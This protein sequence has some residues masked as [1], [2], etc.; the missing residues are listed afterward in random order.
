MGKEQDWKN[1]GEQILDS[2]SGALN[3]GD[4]REL[5]TLV[6]DTVNNAVQE[7]KKQAE[8]EKAEYRDLVRM[9]QENR[10]SREKWEKQQEE[11][12]RRQEERR[13]EWR[14]RH[15]EQVNGQRQENAERSGA[16]EVQKQNGKS[17]PLMHVPFKK[18][19]SV[20]NVLNTVFGSLGMSVAAA[21]AIVA[22]ILIITEGGPAAV[23]WSILTAVVGV[24]SIGMMVKGSKQRGF[25]R[26]AAQYL[27]ICGVKMYADIAELAAETGNSSRFV[28]KDI[29]KM[30]KMGMFPQGHLDEKE[31]CVMLNDEVYRQYTE[32]S[33]AFKMREQMER[34]RIERENRPKTPEELR[35]EEL[36]REEEERK[37]MVA[38]GMEYIRKL[39]DL[40]D[41]IPGEEISQQL[42]QL[43]NLLNQIFDRVQEHPEQMDRIQK[44]MDYYL[45]TMV[46]LV[47]AYVGFEKVEAPGQDI[48]DAKKEIQKTLGVINEAFVELLN[49]LF[50]DEVFD[51]TTDAQVLQT[52][53]AREGLRRELNAEPTAESPTQQ[54]VQEPM[55]FPAAEEPQTMV[56]K[57]PWE[58]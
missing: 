10:E 35:E 23:I 17:N 41:A 4:F 7:A 22:M 43:E 42:S 47:E 44:L 38:Q 5:N 56:M 52:M 37:A 14:L 13:E 50:Q 29:K 48:L 33:K 30:I 25:L 16:Q 11:I 27:K 51:A 8:K 24:I 45:P 54:P 3:S 32:T 34:E 6:S 20:A 1:L 28:K 19:G 53:L 2:V 36:R 9:A 46:K 57:A 15:M 12:R 55:T 18:I 26:R 21:F 58:S 40:N 49:N 39:R 31:T